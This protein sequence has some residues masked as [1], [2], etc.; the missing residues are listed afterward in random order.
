M[1]NIH[2]SAPTSMVKSNSIQEQSLGQLWFRRPLPLYSH[3]ENLNQSLLE[4]SLL[5]LAAEIKTSL[6]ILVFCG[7]KDK[8]YNEASYIDSFSPIH[9]LVA[10]ATL[11][12]P[13]A[14]P[15]I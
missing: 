14:Q 7:F 13:S 12:H 11:Q 9:A 2:P 5:E 6:K 1:V 10:E 3:P 8:I 15:A 4:N